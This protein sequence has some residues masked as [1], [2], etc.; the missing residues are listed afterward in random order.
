MVVAHP[1][2]ETL[3]CGGT[4]AR[5]AAEGDRV[6]VLVLAAGH[7]SRFDRPELADPD[8][9]KA[10]KA[11][12][13]R[14]ADIL[15]V[16]DLELLDYDDCRLDTVPLLDLVKKVE[17][18]KERAQP[19]IVYT[20]HWGDLNVD[21]RII[22]DAVLAAI[23]PLPQEKCRQI[24]AF[25]VPSSTE[26]GPPSPGAAFVANFFVDISDTLDKK[27]CAMETFRSEIRD[28]PHPRS[29]RALRVA[30]EYRGSQV[31]V[32]AAEAFALV[33]LLRRAE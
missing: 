19:D 26:W 31:G 14:A 18:A 9:V 29:A 1:D 15:G 23:R 8:A 20:H 13:L 17:R 4:I 25:E 7:S 32:P 28:Y 2:D 6:H 27:I 33:R 12:A 21:H 10:R 16:S 24:L 22:S 11:D 5:H 30:G 3:G